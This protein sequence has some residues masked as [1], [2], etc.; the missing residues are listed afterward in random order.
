[1]TVANVQVG[2]MGVMVNF[3]LLVPIFLCNIVVNHFSIIIELVQFIV[4]NQTSQ[5]H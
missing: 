5:W 2:W 4:A 1:M 3:H